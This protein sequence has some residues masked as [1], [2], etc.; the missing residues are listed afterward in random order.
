MVSGVFEVAE[1]D[2]V[3]VGIVQNSG[4]VPLDHF[5]ALSG[6]TSLRSTL[7]VARPDD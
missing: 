7:Y 2:G 5:L 1:S 6:N 3:V 4:T